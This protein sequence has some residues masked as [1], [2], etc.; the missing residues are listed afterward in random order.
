MNKITQVCDPTMVRRYCPFKVRTCRF[1]CD[2]VYLCVGWCYKRYPLV[3]LDR[4]VVE[5][6]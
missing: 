2:G 3:V 5:L 1:P 4:L 6:P